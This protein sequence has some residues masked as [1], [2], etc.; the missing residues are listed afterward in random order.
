MEAT[1]ES[2]AT[3]DVAKRIA[4]IDNAPYEVRVVVRDEDAEWHEQAVVSV[5]VDRNLTS[6]D[7]VRRQAIKRT[8]DF[9]S[10]ALEA[11]DAG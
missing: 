3:N 1:V 6:L 7:E 8:R 5:F 4:N 9:L 2:I 11:L 10:N